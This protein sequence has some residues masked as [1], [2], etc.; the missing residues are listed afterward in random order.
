MG[1]RA[2]KASR[3]L[4]IAALAGA[5][6][7]PK[8][9][10][11]PPPPTDAAGDDI[12]LLTTSVSPLV[13]LLLD[14]SVSMRH[15]EWHPAY[16]PTA[17]LPADCDSALE[18][19]GA[20][21]FTATYSYA[22]TTGNE[23]HCGNTRRIYALENPTLWTGHYLAWYFSDAADPYA[24]EIRTAI[25]TA[26]SCNQSGGPSQFDQLYRRRR[27][28]AAKHVLLDLLC[29]A[30]S[31][32]VRFSF[33]TFRANED[34]L[35]LDPNGAFL[36]SD[37]GRSN[38]NHAA[39]LESAVKLATM[40]QEA[41]LSEGLF[42]VY[43]YYM[44]RID[45][46][47]PPGLAGDGAT[48]LGNDVVTSFPKYQYD[49]FGNYE[50]ASNKWFEEAIR[51]SCD[52]AF[53]I[54]VT[55]G[56]SARD[57]F[58]VELDVNKALGF[59]DFANL[60]GDYNP[61]GETEVPLS[62][63]ERTMYL[64]DIAKYMAE[65][66]FRPDFDGDQT[67]DTYAI[68]F[69]SDAATDAFL[70]KTADVGDG[71]FFDAQDGEQLAAALIEALNDI[72]EK[73]QSFTAA[74]VP[75]AR[76]VDG[77]DFYQS[78]FFPVGRSAFWEGHIRAWH[79]EADGDITDAN[80]IC[81]LDDP[82]PGECNSG[83][84]KPS[85]VYFWDAFD[86][87]PLPA[88]RNLMVSKLV[89]GTP[90]IVDFNAS[91]G[92]ADLELA[93]FAAPP[94]PAPNDAL[95]PL[96][97]S[98]ALNAEG[99]AD[100]I[101][102]FVRG[103]TFGTGVETADVAA[104]VP[105]GVR[106]ARFGDVFHSNPV[107][108]KQPSLRSLDASYHAFKEGYAGRSRVLYAGTNGG[109]L[110]A[111]HAGDW[112]AS[113][114]PRPKYDE[115]TGV[116]LFGF[117]PWEPRQQIKHLPVDSAK[118]RRHYVDADAQ[119]ADVWIHPSASATSKNPDGSEWRTIL[120]GGLRE[121]GRHYYA[122]DITNPDG[123]AG[124]GG[125]T[126]PY[127]GYLWEFPREDD[128]DSDIAWMGSTFGQPILTRVRVQNA[129][130]PDPKPIY[131]RWVAIVTAGYAETGDPNPP[132]V[133]NK[134]AVSWSYHEPA[135]RGLF[136]IDLKTGEVLAEKKFIDG[137]GSTC[138]ASP[139]DPQEQM[140]YAIVSTP[141]VLD[142]DADGFADSIYVG[143]IGG[144]VWKWG[145]HA[146]GEDRVND[147]SGLRTQPAWRF[148]KFFDAPEASLS[149]ET[150]YKNFYFP[151]A[152]AKVGSKVWLAFGAGERRHIGFEGVS[153]ST[154]ENNRFYV[155]SDLDPWEVAGTPLATIAEGDGPDAG[156]VADL[157][158]ATA[159]PGGVTVPADRY[160]Y[161]IRGTDGEKFVTR[162]EIFAGYVITASFTPVDTGDPCTS[163]GDGRAYV[164]DLLS[165]EGY[166]ADADGD[167]QRDLDI[168][169]GLPTDPKTSIGV[170]GKDNR[171]YI[172][173]S[174]ADLE[175]FGTVDVPAGGRL[176]YWREAP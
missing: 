146:V 128:P 163:R 144:N 2:R 107:V 154:A 85:A 46:N 124:P 86:E 116:E 17:P 102:A 78:Y 156:N 84:F 151:P 97:G 33:A 147:G 98:T 31:K 59:A 134:P 6:M 39:E 5:L 90:G 89:S 66:D 130:D 168:G 71:L 112:D 30:E 157:V 72:V 53:V 122:L 160:G 16:D 161:F 8:P 167:P 14:N 10:P 69:A 117:M 123:I 56:L 150:Y 40:V 24:N 155:V 32:N 113:A 138:P 34:L 132:D 162:T 120:V 18:W 64:D 152:G 148:R 99:L 133:T 77:G 137:A 170:G 12:F 131:E 29:R 48:P 135:G 67:I 115:G 176:L 103:C 36:S 106:A 11:P 58:D 139:T 20:I 153:S 57:D 171:V 145:I 65:K 62:L 159:S 95:Y 141:A 61:D 110:E 55:D 4:G 37:L 75:S 49:K 63:D 166:F 47:Y 73:A 81:A 93:A 19:G 51:Y 121:G 96:K 105:C 175:S 100:E 125:T 119:V 41:P 35:G 164:F 25:A 74:S 140:C 88:D 3:L 26:S 28:E 42:Q 174:G 111:V 70:Q 173:K 108:V 23:N 83:F 13:V 172:E 87:V 91:L 101:V 27:F 22:N 54:V 143:D 129:S 165:G 21:D 109:F 76:T 44:P 126:L 45:D 94:D 169:A 15:V 50:A 43:T 142:L 136:V 68:G 1:H 127:P 114:S 118:S 92:A 79:I 7:G 104:G 38:P 82:T 149:G 60:I 158:D 52:K 80:G 9:A